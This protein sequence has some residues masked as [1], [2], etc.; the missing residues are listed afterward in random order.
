MLRCYIAQPFE[1]EYQDLSLI[2]D[3]DSSTVGKGCQH[4]RCVRTKAATDQVAIEKAT[5]VPATPATPIFIL[6]PK[7]AQPLNLCK[8]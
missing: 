3:S 5:T 8:L 1:N 6:L 7:T 2:P 4:S